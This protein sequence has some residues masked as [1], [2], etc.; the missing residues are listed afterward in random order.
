MR[1]GDFTHEQAFTA[2][3]LTQL[4]TASGFSRVSCEEHGP[5]AHGPASAARWL[6]WKGLRLFWRFHM[7]VETGDG[8]AHHLFT[9]NF[10]AVADK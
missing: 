9:Q 8:G 10:L 1:Y 5:A 7:A 3:S 6:L 4:L 2:Q